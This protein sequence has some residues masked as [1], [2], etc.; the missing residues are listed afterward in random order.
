MRLFDTLEI[1]LAVLPAVIAIGA[2]AFWW[3]SL[4]HRALFAVTSLLALLGIETLVRRWVV[5]VAMVNLVRDP[6]ASVVAENERVLALVNAAHTKSSIL[7]IVILLVI[8]VSFV[9]WLRR[10]FAVH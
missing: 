2:L 8:S 5:G 3:R 10:A 4:R 6:A 9:V 7:A 1:V